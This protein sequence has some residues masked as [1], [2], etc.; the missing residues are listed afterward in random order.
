MKLRRTIQIF[1]LAFL[2]TFSLPEAFGSAGPAGETCTKYLQTAIYGG[3]KYTCIKAPRSFSNPLGKKLIWSK[4]TL[5]SLEAARTSNDRLSVLNSLGLGT[6]KQIDNQGYRAQVFISTWPCIIY[7][8]NDR[9]EAH[10]IWDYKVNVM[11]YG[12]FWL[13][14]ASQNWVVNQSGNSDQTCVNYF[15]RKYGG[16]VYNNNA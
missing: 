2:M 8:A 5:S 9:T 11:F 6:W 1:T 13:G 15:S 14:I 3:Y 10:A 12:G 7:M 16:T 4:G